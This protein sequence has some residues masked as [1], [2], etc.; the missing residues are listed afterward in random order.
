[1]KKIFLVICLIILL[2]PKISLAEG[3]ELVFK[4]KILEVLSE[5]TLERED[6]STVIQQNL[7]LQGLEGEFKGKEF[8]INGVSDLDVFK[9]I[10][11]KKGDK[12]FVA[13]TIDFEGNEKFYLTDHVRTGSLY[14]LAFLFALL[15]I[16]IGKKHGWTALLSLIVTFFVIMKFIIPLILAGHSALLVSIIGALIILGLVI[17]ITWGF[18]LKAHVAV[19]SIFISLFITGLISIIFSKLASLSG[20]ASE[21]ALFLVNPNSVAI[22]LS[23]LLLAGIIIGTLGVLDDVV[24][25]QISSVE[26]LQEA[27]PNLSKKELYKRSIRIGVDHISSMTNTL[28]LAYAGAALPLLLLFGQ[29][30]AQEVGFTAV[31]NNELIATEIVRTLTG[32][33]G[34]I[35]AVPISTILA[36]KYLKK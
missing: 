20:L 26:Q 32:S 19:V 11:V 3:G 18:K 21:D 1:M 29:G 33:I 2:I 25:S 10:T 4:A 15:L 7:S 13:Q 14:F 28:F 24:I 23:G 16:V 30:G 34:L 36:V 35:L 17:Y 9:S 5:K 8:T 22:D 12:V 27:N 31:I 6:G